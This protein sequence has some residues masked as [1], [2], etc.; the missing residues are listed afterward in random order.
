MGDNIKLAVYSMWNQ[1]YCA[2]TGKTEGLRPKRSAALGV[3]TERR[4]RTRAVSF[5]TPPL[6]WICDVSKQTMC[7][8]PAIPNHLTHV[9]VCGAAACVQQGCSQ[10]FSL[11]INL[12]IIFQR[13]SKVYNPKIFNL[14]LFKLIKA[15]NCQIWPWAWCF[16]LSE[17][18]AQELLLYTV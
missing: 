13:S 15:A 18:T 3:D 17:Q 2:L 4:T 16:F 6:S 11:S 9:V 8:H 7:T 12:L 1:I 5:H 14:H 10:Q